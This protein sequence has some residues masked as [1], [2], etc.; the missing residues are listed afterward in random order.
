MTRSVSG[1]L[2]PVFASQR[3]IGLG[4]PL[5]QKPALPSVSVVL[6]ATASERSLDH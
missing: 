4:H 3:R 1:D 2:T 5:R 6:V